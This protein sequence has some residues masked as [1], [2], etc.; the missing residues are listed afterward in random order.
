MGPT[1]S[2]KTSFINLASGSNLEVGKTVSS[3]TSIVAASRPFDL[4]GRRVTLLDT[5]GFDDTEKETSEILQT[6]A[7]FLERQ[8]KAGV[9]LH[10]VIYVH[11]ISDKKVGKSSKANFSL[12]RRLCGDK[13]LQNVIIMTNMWSEVTEDNG[14]ERAEQLLALDGFFKQAVERH[15][16]MI[17]NKMDTIQSAHNVIRAI[18]KNIPL[19]L[20]IQTELVDEQR[21]FSE[22][23]AGQ[24]V[25]RRLTE[26]VARYHAQL[27]E[28]EKQIEEASVMNDEETM[29]EIA[30]EAARLRE[31]LERLKRERENQSA[32]YES[33]K[34]DF[35]AAEERW[36]KEESRMK[37]EFAEKAWQSNL[38]MVGVA[39]MVLHPRLI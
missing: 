35:A 3:C 34:N 28:M 21:K 32:N 14:L 24:E 33:L 17:H 26:Q 11:R 22:T 23:S 30:D 19:A 9:K 37:S 8:Y 39:A 2:G 10:G 27:M 25:D 1:G 4:D 5:P 31:D 20:S 36:K 18:L 15:A 29:V 38:Y 16:R 7:V 6:I 12:F 13:T